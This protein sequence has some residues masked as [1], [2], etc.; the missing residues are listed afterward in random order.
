MKNL[1][2]DI[3]THSWSVIARFVAR[4]CDIWPAG[5]RDAFVVDQA[6][7]ELYGVVSRDGAWETYDIQ[8]L[9]D[10]LTEGSPWIGGMDRH[11][12]AD[13]C[14][15]AMV[16]KTIDDG[17]CIQIAKLMTDLGDHA[18]TREWWK[19]ACLQFRPHNTLDESSTYDVCDA[20]HDSGVVHD[21][22]NAGG[23]MHDAGNAG[24]NG[25]HGEEESGEEE[26]DEEE[27]D[28]EE[29]GDDDCGA[30]SEKRDAVDAHAYRASSRQ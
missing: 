27:S 26:S 17:D 14:W 3:I 18:S 12:V 30:E 15:Y 13:I 24:G 23:V 29:S 8:V 25:D 1:D 22:G 7:T 20:S 21:A 11:S 2:A 19:A 6:L 16:Q 10:F 5:S 9:R 28:E 4:S